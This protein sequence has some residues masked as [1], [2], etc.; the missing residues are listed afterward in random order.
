MVLKSPTHT[1]RVR[2]LLKLFPKAKFIHIHRNPYDVF[3]STRK[4][5]RSAVSS[6]YFQRPKL[7]RLDDGIIRRYVLMYD[8]FFEDRMLIPKEQYAEVCFEEFEKDPIGQLG[9]IYHSLNIA[10][11]Q[12][13]K[14]AFQ[15]YLNSLAGYKKNKHGL[16]SEDIKEKITQ[17]W[18]RSFEE[19]HYSV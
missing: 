4:L 13:S 11:F 1:A 19:W 9:K 5:Y 14:P 3:Q 12:Q 10:G 7:E 6:S 18:Q 15:D 2:L 16:L 8:A 17:K